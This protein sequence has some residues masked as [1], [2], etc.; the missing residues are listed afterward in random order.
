M[1]CHIL[2]LVG[3]PICPKAIRENKGRIVQVSSI[4]G[5]IHLPTR[6]A[7]GASKAALDAFSDTLRYRW[8]YFYPQSLLLC[9]S[10][11]VLLY[12]NVWIHPSV[13]ASIHLSIHP[14]YPAIFPFL[15]MRRMH[16]I[17]LQP[18]G[19]SVSIVQP[20]YVKTSIFAK[21]FKQT[22]ETMTPEILSIYGDIF[23][24]VSSSSTNSGSNSSNSRTSNSIL[25]FSSKQEI[26][27][28]QT[29]YQYGKISSRYFTCVVPLV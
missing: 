1:S 2:K 7:Y 11:P 4:L 16:R 3:I 25:I 8:E 17:E 28:L 23:Y 19:A 15:V 29:S 5:E 6:G 9:R 24:K 13:H 14:V 12:L 26:T 10:P 22:E 20:A 21:V 27:W 18:L